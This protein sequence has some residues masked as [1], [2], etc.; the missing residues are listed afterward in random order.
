MEIKEKKAM[1]VYLQ[2]FLDGHSIE[3]LEEIIVDAVRIFRAK[4]VVISDHAGNSIVVNPQ[5]F[6]AE[7]KRRRL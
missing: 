4:D 1:R 6:T 3:K 2:Q 7:I 5:T